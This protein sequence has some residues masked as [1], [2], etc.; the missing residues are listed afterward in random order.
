M[1][2]QLDEKMCILWA[3]FYMV[4]VF[5]CIFF[6]SGCFTTRKADDSGRV[7]LQYQKE[8]DRLESEL[9]SRDRTVE[10]AIRELS[11]ISSRSSSMEGTVDE[12]IELFEDYSARV[13]KLLR[14]YNQIRAQTQV[15]NE[16]NYNTASY[17][18]N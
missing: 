17:I 14:D 6:L 11:N 9:N 13:N 18:D 4:F 5:C 16:A 10:Q 12:L 7:L 15:T 3:V 2:R 1:N 8:I